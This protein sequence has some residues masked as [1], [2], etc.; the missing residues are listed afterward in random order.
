MFVHLFCVKG[1]PDSSEKELEMLL[2]CSS[3]FFDFLETVYDVVGNMN[4]KNKLS[5]L[6]NQ[7]YAN[8]KKFIN[9][10]K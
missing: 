9:P 7:S 3:K 8:N 5:H 10:S 2:K 1:S 6:K 4:K